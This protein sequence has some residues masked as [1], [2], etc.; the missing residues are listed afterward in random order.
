MWMTD[1]N[2]NREDIRL[3]RQEM[4]ELFSEMSDKIDKMNRRSEAN[5]KTFRKDLK[6]DIDNN[7]EDI[8]TLEANYVAV[9]KKLFKM[10]IIGGG[11]G[12]VL[13]T[14]T[15]VLAYKFFGV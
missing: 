13:G 4:R 11:I 9:D 12:F 15:T 8:K 2:N 14:V 6:E 3:L 5:C 10:T 7:A 1:E